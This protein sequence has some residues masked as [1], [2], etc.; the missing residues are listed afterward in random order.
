MNRRIQY[1]ILAV[2]IIAMSAAYYFILRH[3]SGHTGPCGWEYKR[4]PPL[5]LNSR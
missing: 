2:G 1:A 3:T 4:K 5:C